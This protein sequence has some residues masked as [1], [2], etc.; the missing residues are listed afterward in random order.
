M[1]DIPPIAYFP[2]ESLKAERKE[3][4]IKML[5]KLTFSPKS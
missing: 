4:A 1:G 5:E 2:V 3:G